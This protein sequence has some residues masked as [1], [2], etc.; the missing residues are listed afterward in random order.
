M[1]RRRGFLGVILVSIQI[2]LAAAV[3]LGIAL[4]GYWYFGPYR[5]FATETFVEIEH[6][7]SSRQIADQL[8]HQGVIRSSWAFMAVRLLHPRAPLQAGEYRF[9]SAQTPWQVF[10]EIRR[11]E[12]FYEDFTVPEGSNMFDIASLLDQSDLV[13]GNAFLKAAARPDIIRDLDPQAPSLEGYLFPSTYRLT[14]RTTA[15]QLC[16]LMTNEFRKQWALLH[17]PPETDLHQTVAIASLVEK[18]SAAPDERPVIASVFL[19][20]LKLHMSLQCDPTT[21]YAALLENRYKGVIHKSDLASENPYNTYAHAGLPPGPI[22]NPGAQSLK[23]ALSPATTDYLYFVAKPGGVGSHVFS[24]TLTEH[25][26][27]V[28]EYRKNAR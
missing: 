22:A 7:M 24:A 14:H 5:G 23:A 9:G 2:L 16:R 17:P 21:V 12:I 15:D 28:L 20:R 4:G 27:A 25:D 18:E 19:N 11:G 10:D 6:G 3:A 1:S 13:R 8:T 26:K